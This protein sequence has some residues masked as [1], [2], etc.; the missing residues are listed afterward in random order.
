MLDA[1]SGE[2]TRMSTR[3]SLLSRHALE[4]LLAAL[5]IIYLDGWGPVGQGIAR[6]AYSFPGLRQGDGLIEALESFCGVL[7]ISEGLVVCY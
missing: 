7:P 6:M 5:D 2:L 3:C 4:L 1:V